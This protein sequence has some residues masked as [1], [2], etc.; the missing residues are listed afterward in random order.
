MAITKCW[1]DHYLATC[2]YVLFV[3][4]AASNGC[5]YY[6][7]VLIIVVD[8]VLSGYIVRI[9][10]FF[11]WSLKGGTLQSFLQPRCI[12]QAIINVVIIMG[13]HKHYISFSES[14]TQHRGNAWYALMYWN[15]SVRFSPFTATNW[16]SV[17]CMHRTQRTYILHTASIL[18]FVLFA[19]LL[20]CWRGIFRALALAPHSAPFTI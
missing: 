14:I 2:T 8:C 3:S 15:H 18:L 13:K 20:L 7:S 11:R 12:T 10:I 5:L 9:S 4:A 19:C 1:T 6:T 16:I 17:L